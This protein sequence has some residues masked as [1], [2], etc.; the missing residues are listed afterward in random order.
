MNNKAVSV[1]MITF[2]L[3]IVVFVIYTSFEIANA[4]ARSETSN[5][6]NLANDIALMV[7]TLVGVPGD[8]TVQYPGD[9]SRYIFVLSSNSITVFMKEDSESRIVTRP[10][11]LP[12]GYEGIGNVEE[13]STLCIHKNNQRIL[14]AECVPNA[15]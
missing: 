1:L 5:K 6:I 12:S 9:V 3:I 11:S 8:A 14:L 7:N 13:K 4:Y 10:F 15:E 2:E